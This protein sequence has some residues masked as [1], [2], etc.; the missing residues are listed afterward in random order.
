MR[1]SAENYAQAFL[2]AVRGK[3]GEE[4]RRIMARFLAVVKKFGDANNLSKILVAIELV[5]TRQRGGREVV[6]E[7]AREVPAPLRK[8]LLKEFGANDL[9]RE[10]TN[11]AL[12]AGGMVLIDGEWMVDASLKR[13][14][15]KLFADTR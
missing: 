1:Y 8:E 14:L 10:R 2:E 4:E 11:L 6:I 7:S 3:S 13:R 15:E 12:I 5:A 9:V